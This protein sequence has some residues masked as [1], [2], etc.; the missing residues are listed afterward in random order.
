MT[1]KTYRGRKTIPKDRLPDDITNFSGMFGDPYLELACAV[2]A[3]SASD[4][5]EDHLV[6][7][8]N[9]QV[10]EETGAK[11]IGTEI[12]RTY[13]QRSK[14]QQVAYRENRLFEIRLNLCITRD[15]L[16]IAASVSR[17]TLVNIEV[18]ECYPNAEIRERI[19]QALGV[20]GDE[21]WP[22]P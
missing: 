4:G 22:I 14:Q 21:I 13:Y 11:A 6:D 8:I 16:A 20:C 10:E 9:H 18:D 5:Y 12:A 1:A 15:Q 17:T 19:S 7:I 2:I 3:A